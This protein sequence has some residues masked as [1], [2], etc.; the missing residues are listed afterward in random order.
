MLH[1]LSHDGVLCIF[2]AIN[3]LPMA[4]CI[5]EPPKPLP[6]TSGLHEFVVGQPSQPSRPPVPSQPPLAPQPTQPTQPTVSSQPPLLSQMQ[7]S[8]QFNQVGLFSQASAVPQSQPI[9]ISSSLFQSASTQ[10]AQIQQVGPTGAAVLS[11]P[12]C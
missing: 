10:P 11:F 5:C 2:H 6:D 8:S 3:I 4:V 12:L 7:P 1:V 9:Q